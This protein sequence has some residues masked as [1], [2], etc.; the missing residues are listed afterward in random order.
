MTQGP[1]AASAMATITLKF[2]DGS[3]QWRRTAEEIAGS[4]SGVV[5]S[6]RCLWVASDQTA[7]V[8]R[9]TAVDAAQTE[10]YAEHRSYRL[11]DFVTLPQ[12]GEN[13]GHKKSISRA[14]TCNG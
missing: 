5:Q 9:L 6:G 12:T 3:G 1:T 13:A 10:S 2:S 7:S 4:I 8:E 14:S 11:G